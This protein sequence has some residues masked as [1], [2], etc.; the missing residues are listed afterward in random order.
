M[1]SSPIVLHREE[2]RKEKLT[3]TKKRRGE[4]AQQVRHPQTGRK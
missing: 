1:L 4:E 2:R 3:R